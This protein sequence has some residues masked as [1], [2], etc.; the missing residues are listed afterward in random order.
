MIPYLL[1]QVPGTGTDF[2]TT[3]IFCANTFQ[4]YKQMISRAFILVLKSK[5]QFQAK[6]F[7]ALS[8]WYRLKE[9]NPTLQNFLIFGG[10]QLGRFGSGFRRNNGNS[11]LD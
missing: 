2:F 10:L 9:Q 5:I 6:N 11:K 3:A 4:V 1:V 7:R 8:A